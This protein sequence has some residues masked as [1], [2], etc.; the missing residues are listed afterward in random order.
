MGVT[1]V[2]DLNEPVTIGPFVGTTVV[3]P[4][5]GGQLSP[6]RWVEWTSHPGVDGNDRPT[7]PADLHIVRVSDATSLVW[8]HV[9]RGG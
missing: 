7:E 6:F 9:A 4:A 1:T 2:R 3:E 5:F 8:T